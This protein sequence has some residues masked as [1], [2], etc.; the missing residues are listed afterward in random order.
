MAHW[1]ETVVKL[2]LASTNDLRELARI[3]GADPK[4]FYIGID[5]RTLDTTD[6]DISDMEFSRS[7]EIASSFQTFTIETRQ[8]IAK[9]IRKTARQEER[10]AMILD[11]I[12]QDR[13]YGLAI[14]E[15]YKS[16]RAKFATYALDQIR[17]LFTDMHVDTK[18][19]YVVAGLIPR[20]FS[21]TYPL[22]RGR[23]LYFL[24]RYLAKYPQINQAIA[25]CLNRTASMFVE[26]YRSRINQLLSGG[27][28]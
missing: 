18:D 14:L 24:A 8:V 20:L 25:R 15:E 17:T 16:D 4:T 28:S 13:P 5:P 27:S 23:L 21:Y 11:M 26:E 7:E 2:L 3:A 19:E 10:I 6:Q 12:V 22:N 9:K 1:L